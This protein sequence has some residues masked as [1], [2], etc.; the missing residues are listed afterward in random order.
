MLMVEGAK[1]GGEVLG[2]QQRFIALNVDVDIRVVL[3]RYG[4]DAIGSAGQIGRG[5]LHGP[6]VLA[7]EICYFVGVGGDQDA[8]EL[9]AGGCCLEDPREHCPSRDAAQ[10]LTGQPRGGESGRD[11]TKNCR[12]RLFAEAGIKYDWIWLCRGWYLSFSRRH[13]PN[14]YWRCSSDG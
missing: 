7:A 14:T 11:D 13:T 8:V 5:E 3:L 9:G 4:A 1:Q 6:A 12:L 10:H 2:F